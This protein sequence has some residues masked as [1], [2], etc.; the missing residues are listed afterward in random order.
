M[1]N[2]SAKQAFLDRKFYVGVL[3]SDSCRCE[4]GKKV[5]QAVCMTCWKRLP[6]YMQAALYDRIGCGFEEAYDDAVQFLSE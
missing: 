3:R 6:K 2:P 1:D 5:G 4:R